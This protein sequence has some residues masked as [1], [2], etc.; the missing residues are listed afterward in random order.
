MEG[1]PP[2]ASFVVDMDGKTYFKGS[3]LTASTYNNLYVPPGVHEFYVSV[4]A[5]SLQ[6]KSKIVSAEFIAKKRMTLKV[7]LRTQASG[8]AP[9][10]PVLDANSTVVATLKTDRFFF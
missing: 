9:V 8:T 1:L 6:K 7:E 2:S 4:S 3:I 5:G 10:P